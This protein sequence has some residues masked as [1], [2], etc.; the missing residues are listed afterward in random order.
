MKRLDISGLRFG[1]LQVLEYSHNYLGRSFWFCLCDCGKPLIVKGGKLN[2]GNQISCGC[3]QREFA[4]FV[5]WKHGES[6]SRTFRIWCGMIARSEVL[7]NPSYPY[8]GARGIGVCQ[9]WHLFANFL[10]DMG[11]CPEG[12]TLERIDNN[13][14]YEPVNC[15]WATRK[16]QANNRRVRKDSRQVCRE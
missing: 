11:H 12:L 1:R 10:A 16:E 3:A 6:R 9:R 8:Y 7:T 4:K 15:R 2:S 13:G 5:N 14:N